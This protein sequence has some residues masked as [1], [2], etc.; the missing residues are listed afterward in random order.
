MSPILFLDLSKWKLNCFHMCGLVVFLWSAACV[1]AFVRDYIHT[2]IHTY[3]H[4][5]THTHTHIYIYIDICICNIMFYIT[6]KL[7]LF[8]YCTQEW[9]GSGD[10]SSLSLVRALHMWGWMKYHHVNKLLQLMMI[11]NIPRGVMTRH[12]HQVGVFLNLYSIAWLWNFIPI[13]FFHICFFNNYFYICYKF[14]LFL[15]KKI[16]FK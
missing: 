1:K 14:V 13:Y 4:T 10:L 5:H 3:T 7:A 6:N 16:Q 15:I 11:D 8:R 2:Y 12:N 9:G